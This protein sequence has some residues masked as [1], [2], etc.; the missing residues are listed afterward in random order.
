MKL[1]TVV[2]QCTRIRDNDES[3]HTSLHDTKTTGWLKPWYKNILQNVLLSPVIGNTDTIR[4]IILLDE[5]E[6]NPSD[7]DPQ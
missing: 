5:D 3:I 7:P 1:Q 4:V 2:K 6:Y